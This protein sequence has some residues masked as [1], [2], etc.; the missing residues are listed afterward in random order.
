MLS[1]AYVDGCFMTSCVRVIDGVNITT[2]DE[3]MWLV[4]YTEGEGH[5]LEI[6]FQ[7][8]R[9]MCGLRVWNYNKSAEDTYRGV[10]H[11][12]VMSYDKKYI[13]MIKQTKI[14]TA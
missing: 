5:L 10:S 7:Q 11:R 4:P 9:S 3:H 2:S 1:Y 13:N 8:V 14:L 6:T 12:D